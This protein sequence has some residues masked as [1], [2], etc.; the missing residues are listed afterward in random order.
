MNF[1]KKVIVYLLSAVSVLSWKA[2][3]Y[4]HWFKSSVSIKYR[5]IITIYIY[6]YN[7]THID[8]LVFFSRYLQHHLVKCEACTEHSCHS[9]PS[10]L[11]RWSEAHPKRTK[12]KSNSTRDIERIEFMFFILAGKLNENSKDILAW[13]WVFFI[14]N[15][16]L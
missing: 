4:L 1:E 9:L 3:I 7:D 14:L 2:F 6:S 5:C 15:N 10:V 8:Y 16:N 13:I 11:F 12:K